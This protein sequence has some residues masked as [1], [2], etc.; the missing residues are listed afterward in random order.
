MMYV[1]FIVCEDIGFGLMVI[2]DDCIYERN[3]KQNL[4]YRRTRNVGLFSGFVSEEAPSWSDETWCKP[5]ALARLQRWWLLS[6]SLHF[7]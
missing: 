3:T 7:K 1:D 4:P 2:M 6:L 5:P